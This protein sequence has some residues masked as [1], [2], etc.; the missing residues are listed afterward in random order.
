M[1]VEEIVSFLNLIFGF[2][3]LNRIFVFKTHKSLHLGLVLWFL[4]KISEIFFEIENE[5]TLKFTWI[6]LFVCF[7]VEILSP[8]VKN[9]R[10]NHKFS[11]DRLFFLKL[12][13]LKMK[14]GHSLRRSFDDSILQTDAFTQQKLKVIRD[15]VFFSQ[16]NETLLEVTEFVRVFK[17]ASDR[18]QSKVEIV[19]SYYKH[20]KL[21]SEFRHRS[22]QMVTRIV[23]QSVFLG[24]FYLAALLFLMKT[25]RL[26]QN[27]D[28]VAISMALFL[29]GMVVTF[30]IP[31][32]FRWRL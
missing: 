20:L 28:A 21:L 15:I 19:E 6:F 22:G 4:I 3:I 17:V 29:L 24:V 25:G 2:T 18:S 13:I 10:V 31:R 16:Q 14:V 5:Q 8:L 23:C 7:L 1:S 32:S 26:S 27:L 30:K 12:I 9:N 11:Q